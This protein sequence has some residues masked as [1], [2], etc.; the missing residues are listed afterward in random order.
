MVLHFAIL[1]ERATQKTNFEAVFKT[2]QTCPAEDPTCGNNLSYRA[3]I[4][5]LRSPCQCW[6]CCS[7][8]FPK[9]IW[10]HTITT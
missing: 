3:L 8:V 1:S 6:L 7:A 4:T 9:H 10:Q 5:L 2:Q